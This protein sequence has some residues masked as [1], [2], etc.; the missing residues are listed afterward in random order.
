MNIQESIDSILG[1]TID[2]WYDAVSTSGNYVTVEYLAEYP[3]DGRSVSLKRFH[4]NKGHR[5]KFDTIM[6]NFTCG[7][8]SYWEGEELMIEASL[9]NKVSDFNFDGFRQALTQKYMEAG[10]TKADHLLTDLR[11]K[12]VFELDADIED[13]FTVENRK[14][15]ADIIRLSF[16]L[17]KSVHKKFANNPDLSM[18]LI[19]TYCVAP[20]RGIYAKA[21][22]K[23]LP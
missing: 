6:A 17:K 11:Y 23:Q 5:I 20:F 18:K 12:D 9:N 13:A 19:E 21:V 2:K 15:K 22:R 14:G 1:R 10:E 7:L 4:D 8:R 16:R 3:N